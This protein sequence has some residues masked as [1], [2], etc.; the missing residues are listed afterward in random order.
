MT[1]HTETRRTSLTELPSGNRWATL[2]DGLQRARLLVSD[3]VGIVSRVFE[4]VHDIDDSYCYAI[5]SETADG[6]HLIGSSN[7]KFNGGGAISEVGTY[8]AAVG[9]C[10][11][12]YS[13]AWVPWDRLRKASYATLSQEKTP[14]VH[15]DLW[16]PFH[17]RQFD[18]PNFD[19]SPFTG[20]VE[21]HWSPMEDLASG[22]EVWV[23]S[24]MLY[25][26]PT[27]PHHERSAVGYA[28][29]NGLAF[30]STPAEA[31]LGGLYELIERDAFMITWHSKLS[32]PLIDIDSHSE[33]SKFMGRY[34][35]PS[36]VDVHLVDLS[37]ISNIPSVL[38]V[39]IN[40][41]T[42][43][44]PVAL[45]AAAGPSLLAAAK[46]AAIECL[47]TRNWVKAEQRDGNALDPDTHDLADEIRS[48][49][50]HIRFYAN[51]KALDRVN[52]LI[53]SEER[54]DVS[55][56][57]DFAG[58]TPNE[59]IRRL[60]SALNAQ[61][62]DAFV[63]DLTSLDVMEAR[64]AVFKVFSPQM[65]MLDVGFHRRFLG[66]ERLRTRARELGFRSAD[67]SYE[68]FNPLPHPF[69]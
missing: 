42:E 3:R 39:A 36:G 59:E 41:H 26:Y 2:K 23:P 65:Q 48:F 30:H 24:Q 1:T 14:G 12:R 63:A 17:P 32:M 11:E 29:S 58:D 55:T 57:P 56:G 28:T 45:G 50:D 69:P 35:A 20:D 8:L 18:D 66:C 54:T 27:D 5:G 68:D 34:V 61:G 15:P 51:S 21:M 16:T 44:A 7:N 47:Q 38:A 62:I 43:H 49:D 9:E 52:F 60:V 6:E 64:G 53:S 40:R 31:I 4:K 33:L 13:G 46:D 25:L 10:V 19:Y 22:K 37:Q 67:M